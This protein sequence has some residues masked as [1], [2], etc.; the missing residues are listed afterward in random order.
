MY[1]GALLCV[2]KYPP[3]TRGG[4]YTWMRFFACGIYRSGVF[5]FRIMQDFTRVVHVYMRAKARV[6]V[7]VHVFVLYLWAGWLQSLHTVF[8]FFFLNKK[9]C[10]CGL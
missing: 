8:F 6:C 4:A 5:Q 1:S 3:H 7:C 2:R 10:G 9:T